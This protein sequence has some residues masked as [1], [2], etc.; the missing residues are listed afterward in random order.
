MNLET[1][2][3]LVEYRKKHN[4]SQE[5]VA[6]KIGVSRQAVSKW[7]RVEASPDTDNLIA[8]AQLYNVSLDE[9]V[10]GKTPEPKPESPAAE[11]ESAAE[12]EAVI[13][14]NGHL[15]GGDGLR[16]HLGKD[17]EE[18]GEGENGSGFSLDLDLGCDDDEPAVNRLHGFFKCIPVPVITAI[19]YLCFGFF[20]CMGGWAYGWLIFFAIPVYYSFVSAVAM[21]N[22]AKVCYPVLVAWVYL[23]CGFVYG[24]WHPLWILFLTVPIYYPIAEFAGRLLNRK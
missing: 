15:F 9:L 23:W 18:L 4:L 16:I 20:D 17:A 11:S 13:A 14:P 22:P 2:N 5:E 21:R 6:E 1:A 19:A 7:E 12:S 3:R 24:M 8:L 10:L